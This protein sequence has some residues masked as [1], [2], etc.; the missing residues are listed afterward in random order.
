MKFS[1]KDFF[2]KCFLWIWPHLLRKCLMKNFIFCVV[3]VQGEMSWKMFRLTKFLLCVTGLGWC[4]NQMFLTTLVNN[5]VAFGVRF[6]TCVWPFKDAICY[7]AKVSWL[8]FEKVNKFRIKAYFEKN[9][10]MDKFTL[11]FCNELHYLLRWGQA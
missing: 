4:L 10:A 8:T 6:V 5:P 2:I 3:D 1:I 9:S 7:R 11:W